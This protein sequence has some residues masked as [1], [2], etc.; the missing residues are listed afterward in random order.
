MT[1]CVWWVLSSFVITSLGKRQL[2]ALPFVVLIRLHCP[3]QCVK[4]PFHVIGRLCS[5]ILALS[6]TFYIAGET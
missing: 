3:S 1:C 4:F 2:V 6:D 5:A